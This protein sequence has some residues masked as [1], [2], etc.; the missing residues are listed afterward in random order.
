[1]KLVD[2]NLSEEEQLALEELHQYLLLGDGCWALSDIFLTFLGRILGDQQISTEARVHLLRALAFAALKDDIILL[3]HQDRRDHVMMN[4]LLE[5]EK[6]KPEEQ[7]AVALFVSSQPKMTKLILTFFLSKAC[8][9]F[10]NSNASEWLLYISEWTYNNAPTS[11]IR[12]TTKVVVHSLLSSCPKL[13]ELG[14]A[15]TYNLGIKE[16][17][18][19]V[20]YLSCFRYHF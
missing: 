16:V 18:T 15:L 8:N 3:L 19:V 10:E 12:A 4:Y 20:K 7:Q 5:I 9:L 17:K 6:H 1:M 11:N 14:A 13:Q 2:G